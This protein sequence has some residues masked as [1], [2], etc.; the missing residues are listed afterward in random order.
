[1]TNLI[2]NKKQPFQQA[3]MVKEIVTNGTKKTYWNKVG[4]TFKHANNDGETLL[5]DLHGQ[6][7]EI[8]LRPFKTEVKGE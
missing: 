8:V 1:M 5:L 2:K 4:V 3:F 7:L 6:T